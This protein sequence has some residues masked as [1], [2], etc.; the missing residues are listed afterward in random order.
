VNGPQ[1]NN[2]SDEL[3]QLMIGVAL[4]AFSMIALAVL[5][6]AQVASILTR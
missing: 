5:L 1:Q 6:H 4:I 3:V 2:G